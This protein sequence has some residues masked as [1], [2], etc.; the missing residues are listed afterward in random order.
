MTNKKP[1]ENKQPKSTNAGAKVGVGRKTSG[2]ATPQAARVSS[3][4]AAPSDP[5]HASALGLPDV[6]YLRA[7]A[8]MVEKHGLSEV[9]LPLGSGTLV[10]RRGER[11]SPSLA[12]I[13]QQGMDSL[14]ALL[15]REP[16]GTLLAGSVPHPSIPM[17]VSLPLAASSV[18]PQA[19]NT[20]PAASS[21]VP[22]SAALPAPPAVA[23]AAP[24]ASS[25]TA[26]PPVAQ[27]EGKRANVTSPFVGTFYRAPSPDSSPYVEPGQRV[28]KGQVLC[29][30]EAMKL[31]NEIEAEVDGVIASCHV[32][33]AQP[34]EYGQ[35]LFQIAIG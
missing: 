13:Q 15:P 22:S 12:A 5:P 16:R 32:E 8:A 7:V 14:L 1:S 25:S 24:V 26:P 2:V 17:P 29:I 31:M 18:P 21:S 35:L 19:T 9:R 10:V 20:L 6:E 28:K 33:N 4:A 3:V 27:P 11:S 30:V 23:A 34:V